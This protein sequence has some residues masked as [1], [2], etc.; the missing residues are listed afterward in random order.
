[1]SIMPTTV[2]SDF[3]STLDSTKAELE[4]PALIVDTEVMHENVQTFVDFAERH[5]VVLR[6]HAKSHKIPEL[7]HRQHDLTGGGIVCQKLSEAEVMAT[8]GIKDIYLSYIVVGDRK[9]DRVCR[10]SQRLEYFATTVDGRENTAQLQQAAARNQTTINVILEVD[11]G[12]NR[13]GVASGQPA[14]ELASHVHAQPNLQLDGIMGYEGH[15][16]YGDDGATTEEEYER[17]CFEAMDILAETADSIEAEGIT[18]DEV[19]A[20]S[21]ATALY[22]GKHPAVTEI[23]PGMY[24]FND[25]RLYRCTPFVSKDDCAVT[26]LSTVISKPTPNRAVVDAGSKTISLDIDDTP[27]PRFRDDI[28]YYKGSEEHGWIDTSSA[29]EPVEV[30]DR[31]EFIIPHVCTTINLH[32]VLL[33]I[34]NGHVS[35]LWE[36][37]A[38]GKVK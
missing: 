25:V 4:T 38:R 21:T 33:G 14:V 11:V 15:I 30:G 7:A 8:N 29:D 37:A 22:T 17:R 5:D 3:E 35:D 32:D 1:M 27:E 16:G 23:H 36:V 2:P 24:P 10:L 34:Q 9:L 6:S 18:V 12:L 26:V 13:V 28:S 19:M 31:I 20:G